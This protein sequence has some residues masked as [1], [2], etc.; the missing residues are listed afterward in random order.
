MPTGI[1]KF[2]QYSEENYS[3]TYSSVVQQLINI[4]TNITLSGESELYF[5]TNQTELNI[6]HGLPSNFVQPTFYNEH[7]YGI[8]QTRIKEIFYGQNTLIVSGEPIPDNFIVVKFDR[9]QSG[10]VRL[11]L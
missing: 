1:L 7:Y 10:A 4:N 9:P 3:N 5:F 8:P 2:I 6:H 11:S